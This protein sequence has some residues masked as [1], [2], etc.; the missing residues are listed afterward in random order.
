MCSCT[1]TE[2]NYCYIC[3]HFACTACIEKCSQNH[4]Y[5]CQ[6]KSLKCKRMIRLT[7]CTIEF[8]GNCGIMKCKS[9]KCNC[10]VD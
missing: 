1:T 7:E 10:S 5:K 8:C 6:I 3:K 9:C 4:V 2:Q